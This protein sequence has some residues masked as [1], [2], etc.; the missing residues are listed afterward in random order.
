[1]KARVES[2]GRSDGYVTMVVH[3][4]TLFVGRAQHSGVSFSVGA[5]RSRCRLC[6]AIS[7]DS[8]KPGAALAFFVVFRDGSDLFTLVGS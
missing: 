1:M 3:A 2:S 8:V 5:S 4:W 6:F 7:C